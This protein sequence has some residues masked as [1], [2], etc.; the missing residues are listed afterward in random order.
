MK[1]IS[2]THTRIHSMQH[3][4]EVEWI[5]FNRFWKKLFEYSEYTSWRVY[6]RSEMQSKQLSSSQSFKWTL[7]N[8]NTKMETQF[9]HKMFQ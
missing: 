2:S 3:K 7:S 6:T 1:H 8:L 9:Q 5:N 4:A